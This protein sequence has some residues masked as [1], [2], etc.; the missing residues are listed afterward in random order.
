[1]WDRD[2]LKAKIKS[3]NSWTARAI[4]RLSTDFSSIP[5]DLGIDESLR[6]DDKLFFDGLRTFFSDNGFF[7]DRHISIARAKIR[8][9]YIDFLVVIANR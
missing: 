7:T 4:Y 3:S 1:M 8:D 5:N 2:S 6:K 9:P